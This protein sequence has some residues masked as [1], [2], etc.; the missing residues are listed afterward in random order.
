[1]S[2]FAEFLLIAIALYLWEST[3]WLP[4]RGVALR[5]RWPGGQWRIVDP[6]A[7][8]ATRQLGMVPLLPLPPDAGLAP[9][10]APPVVV[11][12]DGNFLMESA[13][14]RL[15]PLKPLG[16]DDFHEQPHHL[17]VA[18]QKT[19]ISSPRCIEVLRRARHRGA[20]PEVAVRQAWRLAL[21]PG[22]SGR[23]WRRWKLVSGPLRWYGPLLTLGFLVG[24]PLAYVYLGNLAT[25]VFA[26]WLWCLMGWTAAH[27][28]WLGKRV[29]PGAR[30]AL[31]MDALLALVV[32]FHAMRAV[33]LAAVHAMGT[34]H[35]LGLILS[36]GDLENPWLGRFVRRILH[37]MP[38]VAQDAGFSA[39]LRPLL[40]AA[41]S[42]SGKT[43]ND[44]DAAPSRLNDPVAACYCPRCH[45]LYLAHASTCP[46]CHGL[47]LRRFT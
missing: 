39:A 22:R 47:A 7:W 14:G 11:G 8:I 5:R 2:A 36:S 21:S 4:L 43:P 31:R 19:R 6:A 12:A 23:E 20:T 17:V 33:E 16:W 29:Y 10:Q 34:T 42:Q 35:P 26:L 3:L 46:D 25:V 1:M 27:L 18:G 30:S 40:E 28:W 32:P 15:H 44:F 13:S 37:P 41:L 45:G 24:L 38:D 9:C